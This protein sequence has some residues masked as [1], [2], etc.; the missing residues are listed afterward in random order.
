MVKYINYEG[1]DY[2]IRISYYALKKLKETLGRSLSAEDDGT[3]Y[4]VYETLLFYGLQKGHQKMSPEETFP[5]KR[6][7]MEDVMDEVYID[8]MKLVPQ[9]FSELA[10]EEPGKK[11]GGSVTR[12][13]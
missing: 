13:K 12:K 5:F 8:F 2:P 7:D 3:D 9:F 10:T 1:K 6:E 11:L 4:E